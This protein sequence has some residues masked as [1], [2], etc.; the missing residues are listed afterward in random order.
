M[1][2]PVASGVYLCHLQVDQL[3]YTSKMLLVR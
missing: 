1:G 3:E 2:R